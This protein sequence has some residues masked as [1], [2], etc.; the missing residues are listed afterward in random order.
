MS[1]ISP[2]LEGFRAA[3]RRPSL[4]LAEIAWRWTVGATTCALLLFGFFEY[5]RTLPVTNGDLLFLRTRQPVLIGQAIS[6]I[7][8]GSLDRAA[9]AGLLAALALCFAWIVAASVGRDL[10]LRALLE[11]FASRGDVVGDVY[12][13]AAHS[14]DRAGTATQPLRALFGLNFFRAAVMLAAALAFQGAAI[15]ARFASSPEHPRP[16]LVFLLFLPLAGLICMAAWSLNWLLSLA[17]IFAVRDRDDTLGSLSS[18]VG[19]CRERF[20]AIVAVSSWSSAAHL[21]L[22]GGMMTVVSF[23]LGLAPLIKARLLIAGVTLVVLIY[24]AIADWL[25]VARLAGYVSIAE[26]P[27]ALATSAPMPTLPPSGERFAPNTPVQT[28]DRGETILSD[29]PSY[30]I[31][32]AP[33]PFYVQCD[34]CIICGAP[35]SVA[36]DLIGFYKRSIRDERPEPLLFQETT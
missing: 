5:L 27:E 18:A 12:K 24:L 15:L 6:H 1:R 29:V 33:G 4:F 21:V 35:E 20:G 23:P 36:P 8:R 28:I 19:L 17:A 7:L 22:F 9:L 26:M 16:G 30:D 2:T 31:D 25:Y 11:Y 14:Q 34:E 10:T 32:N 3:W 13:K